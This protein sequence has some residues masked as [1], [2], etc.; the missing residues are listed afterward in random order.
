MAEPI[1]ETKLKTSDAKVLEVCP[2]SSKSQ[3]EDKLSEIYLSSNKNLDSHIGRYE[4]CYAGYVKAGRFR[5]KGSSGGIIKWL[6]TRLLQENKI[7]YLIQLSQ[8]DS[9][10]VNQPL[11]IYK[12]YTDAEEVINGSKSSYYPVSLV[13][14]V[15][16]IKYHKGKFAIT[17]VPCFIKALRLL[18][19]QDAE[20]K[21]R[22]TF[23]FGLICGGMKSANQSKMI[24]WQLGV[25][26]DNL[27]N[28]DFRRKY[29][30]RP[31]DQKIYQ[32][33]SK[34]DNK[35]R[36]KDVNKIYGTDY[37]A[38][39]FKPKAC[40]YCDDVVSEL[41]DISVGDAWLNQFTY[42]PRG[43][44]LIIVRNSVLGELLKNGIINNEIELTEL[45][46]EDAYMTQAGGFRHRRQGLSYRLQKRK[47]NN[48][49]FPPKR[50]LPGEFE[51]DG[52]KKNIYD[53]REQI[54]ELS[55]QSF[56]RALDKDDLNVFYS[57]MKE[58]F[59]TYRTLNEVSTIRL[60]LRKLKRIFY[61]DV[62]RKYQ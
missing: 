30:N 53:L 46:A 25:H 19:E 7:D 16:Y 58:V 45:S 47:N 37:G 10:D 55:H 8:N 56:K 36:Y 2:F 60:F 32:V 38:G 11:F 15:K 26:P 5:Q 50:V 41:A 20:V 48:E 40:D 9:G 35:E 44:S 23:T 27:I 42:D 62:L 14:I 22:L 24:G 34:L 52:R 33:W 6:A 4:T 43:T 17:G 28:I 29:M 59:G 51:V 21:E 61:Y 31:A 49:W 1:S 3:D 54:S 18:S 39:F 57:E 13:E 12:V